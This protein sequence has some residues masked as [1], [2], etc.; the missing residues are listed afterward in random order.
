MTDQLVGCFSIFKQ[1]STWKFRF[2][3][4]LHS[5]DRLVLEYI[6]NRLQIGNGIPFKP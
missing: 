3:I 5:D 4:K 6:K 1:N 2:Q